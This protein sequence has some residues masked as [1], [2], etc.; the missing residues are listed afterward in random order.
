MLRLVLPL[1]FPE[2]PE[3]NAF[4]LA[5]DDAPTLIDCGIHDPAR[6]RDGGFPALADAVAAAGVAVDSIPRLVVTHPHPDHYGQAGRLVSG[7]GTDLWM[8]EQAGLDL[9]VYAAPER[10]AARVRRSFAGHGVP[11][12][13]LDELAAFEDWGAFLSGVV[14]ATTSIADGDTLAVGGRTWEVVHTPGHARS[15][16]CLWSGSDR[17]LVSGD[18][19]LQT[20]T[21]HIDFEHGGEDPLGDYLSSLA[22]IEALAPEIVLPGHGRPFSNGAER[23]AAIARHHER[24]LGG[25][26]QVIRRRPRTANEITDEVFGPELLHFHKRLALGE[27]LAH[28][29]YL[30]RRSE[31][32]HVVT[33]D[34]VGYVK[35]R[36]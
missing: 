14:T 8:H 20:A 26:L 24:R 28:L 9:E 10:A 19:L 22:R 27:A 21:P 13:E 25:I 5:D 17:I 2:L 31:V 33:G 18:H 4:L 36:R 15:H 23:A 3:A 11:E 30:Y 6:G 29:E 12:E 35:A 34:G 1:P 7:F 32:E 16:V